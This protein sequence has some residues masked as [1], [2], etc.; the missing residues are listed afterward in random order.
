MSQG[1]TQQ[2][3]MGNANSSTMPRADDPRRSGSFQPAQRYRKPRKLTRG[4][5]SNTKIINAQ[6]R[7]MRRDIKGLKRERGQYQVQIKNLNEELDDY[8]EMNSDLKDQVSGLQDGLRRQ[9][10]TQ[11][12]FKHQIRR[13]KDE[14]TGVT[15]DQQRNPDDWVLEK[16]NLIETVN[17]RLKSK[18]DKIKDLSCELKAKDAAS[19]D[20]KTQIHKLQNQIYE[21]KKS[22]T[23]AGVLPH[24]VTD[25]TIQERMNFLGLAVR[26]WVLASFREGQL[27]ALGQGWSEGTQC[28]ALEAVPRI[29]ELDNKWKVAIC[30]AV[31]MRAI[32]RVFKAKGYFGLPSTGPLAGVEAFA[33]HIEESSNF[34]KWRALTYG[35]IKDMSNKEGINE[36]TNREL[37]EL[38]DV[39]VNS[40]SELMGVDVTERRV[41]KLFKIMNDAVALS[42]D[43]KIQRSTYSVEWPPRFDNQETEFDPDSMELDNGGERDN[44]LQKTVILATLPAVFKLGDAHGDNM[45][46]KFNVSKA[47]VLCARQ[48]EMRVNQQASQDK[49][50][51][52]NVEMKD[53]M[54]KNEH[55][56]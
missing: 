56:E 15:N 23:T 8:V 27:K 18:N 37:T 35:S 38:G 20:E 47:K 34:P 41:K 3:V 1:L 50:N 33:N 13:L 24:Q 42:H 29:S 36:D 30:Q 43:L 21:L 39:T 53:T 7:R 9:Y 55:C 4:A 14:R 28:I 49:R 32:C 6:V 45:N 25:K 22:I 40:L 17:K 10:R 52:Q 16:E 48:E 12:D 54:V 5:S 51:G 11:S 31:A 2:P 46:V 19:E 44:A 26:D